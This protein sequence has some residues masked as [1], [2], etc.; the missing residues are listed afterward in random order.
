MGE[1]FFEYV[2]NLFPQNCPHFPEWE[3]AFVSLAETESKISG[4]IPIDR[5]SEAIF[6]T[7]E[8]FISAVIGNYLLPDKMTDPFD[9]AYTTFRNE[10]YLV[11]DGQIQS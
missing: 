11:K 8:N 9:G 3:I 6:M 10:E 1:V 4:S 7:Y 2:R 5:V